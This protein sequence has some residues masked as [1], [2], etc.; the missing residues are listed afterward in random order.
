MEAEWDKNMEE[1]Y[2]PSDRS[3]LDDSMKKW[4][5]QYSCPAFMVVPRKPW[6]FGNE[7][8]S[9]CDCEPYVMYRVKLVEREDRPPEL[10]VGEFDEIGK[11]VGKMLRLTKPIWR[12]E[13]KVTLDSGFCV[14]RG[15]VE[16]QKRGVYASIQIKKRKY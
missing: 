13:T 4:V 3:C 1:Q 14:A 15:L 2:A 6:P 11:A 9:I 16:L 12:T 8:I 5:N 10:G 7:Y